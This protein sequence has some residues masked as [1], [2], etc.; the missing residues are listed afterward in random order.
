MSTSKRVNSTDSVHAG[1]PRRNA[2]DAVSMPIVQTATYAFADTAEIQAYTSGT[3]EN[4]ERD[5]YGRYGNPTVR[6]VE[7]RVAA[8]DCTGDALLLS[9]GMAALTT[10]LLALVRSGQHVI[11][12]RDCYRRTQEF[13][14]STLARFGVAHSLIDS[15]D[16][17]ALEGAIRPET[18]I[19]LTECP[20]N[21]HLSCVDLQRLVSICRSHRSVKTIVDSTLAT[22]INCR[23]SEFGIDLVVHSATKY[24]AG[25]NDVLAGA[26][27]GS[28]GLISLVRDLRGVVGS[29]CDPHAAFLVGRGLKTLGLR[30]ERQ[31]SS[32][33]A[34][35]EYLERHPR[36][37]R[38]Y[39]PGLES[40]P[41]YA[42]ARSQM[43]GFGGVV[44]FVVRGGLTA[45][46]QFVD[47]LKIARIGPS[48]G[49]VET[50]VEQ[51]AVMSYYEMTTEE[52]TAIEIEDGLVRLAVGVE[53]IGDIVADVEQ[54]LA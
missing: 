45:A 21:P 35:A 39:Y 10:T 53:D 1:E 43:S 54:A 3:H 25:H 13:V 18:R 17:D 34:L 4:A 38:V 28:E 52:R 30:V 2:F 46:A 32:A 7:K 22:P 15:C 23:P 48:F 16:L 6:V 33:L 51:P 12:F 29:V 20:T 14:T 41:T 47:R 27:G 11:L 50:L 37:D 5:E 8:L 49:G 19:V 42:I 31:N 36:I 44:S 40:H 24:I 9:S 26:V